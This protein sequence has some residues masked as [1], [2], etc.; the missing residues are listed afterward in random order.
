[1][2]H[3]PGPVHEAKANLFRVLGHPARVRILELLQTGERTVG[4]L[5]EELGLDSGGTSQHLAQLRRIGAVQSRREGTS[6]HYRVE[7]PG[8][9]ELLAVARGIITRHLSEQQSVLRELESS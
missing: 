4:A 5:Q 2:P 9:L 1:V 7:D 3:N 6:V 8:V